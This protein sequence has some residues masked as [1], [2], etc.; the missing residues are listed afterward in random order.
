MNAI[1]FGLPKEYSFNKGAY[2]A[3][4]PKANGKVSFFCIRN[5]I[6]S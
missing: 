4:T 3:G 6:V 5:D 2:S 1:A